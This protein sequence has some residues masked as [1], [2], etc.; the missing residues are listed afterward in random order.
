MD[1]EARRFMWSVLAKLRQK[2][3]KCSIIL[4]THSM[5]EAEA[6]STKM[7]IMVNGGNFKCM[8]ST[9]H[10]KHKFGVGYEIE[11]KIRPL[12]PA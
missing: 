10:I 6:L 5:E 12:T 9:H 7:G 1:P 11:I 2:R 4:T 8:G 3:K